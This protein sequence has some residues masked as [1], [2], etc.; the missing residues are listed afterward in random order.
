M[1]D[2]T[3]STIL[4]NSVNTPF[5]KEAKAAEVITPGQFITRDSN[6]E[7][8]VQGVAA[9]IAPRLVAVEN[10]LLGKGIDYDYPVGENVRAVY[11]QPGY[12]VYT[13]VAAG[14]AVVT[15]GQ[16]VEFN[17]T[18]GVQAFLSGIQIG[19]ALETVDN[20]GGGTPAR[21]KIELI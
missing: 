21:I 17:A 19:T 6:L 9:D 4:L 3:P 1:S 14:A 13:T 12:E 18:G 10:N 7:Y 11:M 5:Y 15:A 8:T 2:L 20:S 16:Y